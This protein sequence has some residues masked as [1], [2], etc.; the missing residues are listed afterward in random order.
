MHLSF[1][2][3]GG[4]RGACLAMQRAGREPSLAKQG[5]DEGRFSDPD[6]PEERD[7]DVAL[8]EP[9]EHGLDVAQ[10]FRQAVAHR[11]RQLGV[12]DQR[13]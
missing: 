4:L 1:L 13:T 6:A 7:V 5:I 2:P 12:L 11:R 9:L 8:L 10:L 3:A